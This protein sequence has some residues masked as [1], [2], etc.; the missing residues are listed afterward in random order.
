MEQDSQQFDDIAAKLKSEI[1]L[2]TDEEFYRSA[3]KESNDIYEHLQKEY[4][5]GL[6]EIE[7]TEHDLDLLDFIKERLPDSFWTLNDLSE[8]YVYTSLV[9]LQKHTHP[10][11][12]DFVKALRKGGWEGEEKDPFPEFE[13]EEPSVEYNDKKGEDDR[14]IDSVIRTIEVLQKGISLVNIEDI[15]LELFLNQSH[16][17]QIKIIRYVLSNDMTEYTPMWNR[18]LSEFWWDDEVK[19]DL[20][21]WWSIK[22]AAHVVV[23]RFPYDY[24][25][26][27]RFELGQHA[28]SS[29]CDL[30]AREKGFYIDKSRL[31]RFEYLQILAN[32]HIHIDD[33]EADSLLF[34]HIM[35]WL[36]E[37]QRKVNE[38]ESV[39]WREYSRVTPWREYSKV[40]PRGIDYLDRQSILL[41]WFSYKPSLYEVPWVG[42]YA[43]NL[44]FTGNTNTVA[45]LIVWNQF[46]RSNLQSYLEENEEGTIKLERV[47]EELDDNIDRNWRRFIELAIETCPVEK[48]T[49]EDWF[50]PDED[51]ELQLE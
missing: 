7:L 27:H 5:K 12:D 19:P 20:E 31:K 45:K 25:L 49:I 9:S 47:A 37:M 4:K 30:L 1:S 17:N 41:Y 42:R 38:E 24:V 13:I 34:D 39:D 48:A 11:V 6:D 28:Y 26:E 29:V 36:C 35:I 2:Q 46:L 23:K 50:M 44:C 21:K 14:D 15:L 22:E 51:D 18:I 33:E 16:Q 3:L 40:I 32:N 43:T 8:R 10:F